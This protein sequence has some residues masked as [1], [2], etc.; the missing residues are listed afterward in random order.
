MGKKID[1]ITG[2]GFKSVGKWTYAP[3]ARDRDDYDTLKNVFR[4]KNLA[5]GD[6]IYTHTFYVN[7][8]P[9]FRPLP[10]FKSI[11]IDGVFNSQGSRSI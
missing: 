5:D 7:G 4:L 3:T 10:V 6:V 8:E 2:D 11:A 1:F 9:C